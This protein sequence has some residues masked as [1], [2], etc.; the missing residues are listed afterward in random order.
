MLLF[1]RVQNGD[2]I[3][4]D[5]G[6]LLLMN[7]INRCTWM[8][9]ELWKRLRHL[10]RQL[11]LN[12]N[13][14]EKS[15]K[16]RKLK[17]LKNLKTKRKER[18]ERK[19]LRIWMAFQQMMLLNHLVWKHRVELLQLYLLV[20]KLQNSSNYG[21]H[22]SM[23]PLSNHRNNEIYIACYQKH[24]T[25]KGSSEGK[26]TISPVQLWMKIPLQTYIPVIAS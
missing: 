22:D 12:G 5:G 7:L 24:K 8:F 10:R 15:R 21:N 26:D 17:K 25:R 18:K 13:Y 11:L 9:L 20:L 2:F 6:S 14:G 23:S 19:Y 16:Q 1:Q 3:L 4:V